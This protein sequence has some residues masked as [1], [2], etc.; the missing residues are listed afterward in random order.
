MPPS[1]SIIIL[2]LN[3]ELHIKRCL[4]SIIPITKNIFIIDSNSTDN[5]VKIAESMGATVLKHDWPGNHALQFQWGLD[6][7]NIN[8][9]W[10]MKLD[11]D[12]YI[13]IE[14][15]NEIKEK[16]N[17]LPLDVSGINLKRRVYFQN[18]WIKHGGCYPIKLLRIWRHNHGYVENR[19]M[20]EHVN[21]IKGNTIEFDYDFSDNNLNDLTWWTQKHNGYATREA[22]DVLISLYDSDESNSLKP[23]WVGTQAQVKR[24]LKNTYITLPLFIRP[25]IYFIYRYFIKL[26]FLDGKPGLVWCILQGFWYRFLVDAK[27]YEI[28]N[29]Y[30]VN[31]KKSLA[32]FIDNY[33]YKKK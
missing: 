33:F 23:S 6:N 12:E 4:D 7:C 29:K 21:L 13:S 15:A 10:V 28:K 25:F 30:L 16:L 5:T 22:I 19:W 24:K 26:G 2:T 11:A 31:D 3:E 9:D 32:S 27:I 8:T 17:H 20:D 1:L 14:L 18:R